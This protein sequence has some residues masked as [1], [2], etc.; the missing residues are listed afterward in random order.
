ML[1][2][3]TV[4]NFCYGYIHA[5]NEQCYGLGIVLHLSGYLLYIRVI[6]TLA[7]AVA[8]DLHAQLQIG[9]EYSIYAT[10]FD[11]YDN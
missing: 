2:I 3:H 4:R 1:I 7:E 9:M 5:K 11:T 6:C 8:V 10:C